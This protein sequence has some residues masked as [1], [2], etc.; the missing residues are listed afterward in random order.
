MAQII[1]IRRDT[2]ANWIGVDPI[3][4]SGEAALTTDNNS[5]KY[6]DGVNIWSDLPYFA[7]GGIGLPE[8]PIDSKPYVRENAAWLEGVVKSDLDPLY[9]SAGNTGAVLTFDE[10]EKSYNAGTPSSASIVKVSNV[11]ALD[12]STVMFTSDGT[13]VTSVE[14]NGTEQVLET[15]GKQPNG[16]GVLVITYNGTFFFGQWRNGDTGSPVV[17]VTEQ[18]YAVVAA[19]VGSYLRMNNVLDMTATL[20]LSATV[21]GITTPIPIGAEI[22]FEMMAAGEVEIAGAVGVSFPSHGELFIRAQNEIIVVKHVSLNFYN[23]IG[24]VV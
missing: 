3:L 4:A 22:E 20:P 14:A 17:T 23:V 9:G 15:I 5:V 11:G 19:D 12:I 13:I 18:A 21:S 1:Q 2:E 6:G 7:G 8:A 16:I 10:K 24:G